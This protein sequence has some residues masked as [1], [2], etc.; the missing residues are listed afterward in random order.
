[1]SI[2]KGN[3]DHTMRHSNTTGTLKLAR[4]GE[5]GISALP[6]WASMPYLAL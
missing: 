2:Q 1:M 4:I 6:T 3:L 5:E